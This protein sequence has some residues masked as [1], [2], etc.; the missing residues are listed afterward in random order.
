MSFCAYCGII[1]PENCLQVGGLLRFLKKTGSGFHYT[2]LK[3]SA[4]L[5]Y[6]LILKV[7][8]IGHAESAAYRVDVEIDVLTPFTVKSAK[9]ICSDSASFGTTESLQFPDVRQE[10]LKIF[11]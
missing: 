8:E 4:L 11:R 7:L 6:V 5:L 9:Q 10:V 1:Y 2:S 3:P